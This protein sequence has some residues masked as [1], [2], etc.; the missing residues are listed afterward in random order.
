M[1]EIYKHQMRDLNS[2]IAHIKNRNYKF[3]I[4]MDDL[5]FEDSEIE[6]KYLKAVIEGGLESRPDNVLIYATSNRRHLIQETWKDN[7]DME[8]DKHHSDTMQE[9]LSLVNRFG[10]TIGFI[11]PDQKAFFNIVTELAKRHPE[12]KM[13]EEKL[14]QEATKWEISHGGFSGRSAQQFIDYTL[15]NL[16]QFSK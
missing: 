13:D 12:I 3:I 14:K 9:K 11:K 4:Y 16:D 1:I 6:Y 8:L 5:S 2:V 7:N 15:G 10:I